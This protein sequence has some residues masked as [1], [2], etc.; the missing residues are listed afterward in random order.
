MNT[1][2]PAPCAPLSVWKI[3]TPHA[4]VICPATL[5]PGLLGCGEGL[6]KALPPL[7][8]QVYLRRPVLPGAAG[9]PRGRA[10]RRD[11]QPASVSAIYAADRNRCATGVASPAQSRSALAFP[12]PWV[13]RDGSEDAILP[14][15]SQSVASQAESIEKIPG[16]LGSS[17]LREFQ[18][19]I[20]VVLGQRRRAACPRSSQRKP[21]EVFYVPVQY[22]WIAAHRL[23]RISRPGW[24]GAGGAQRSASGKIEG[25]ISQ[26]G[27]KAGERGVAHL[28]PGS[29]AL[30]LHI[31][32]MTWRSSSGGTGYP[33]AAAGPH[34]APRCAP[35][36]YK[37]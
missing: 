25:D 6:R 27:K 15:N 32:A 34:G 29:A 28:T 9:R 18:H 14:G 16:H 7:G 30:P 11:L 5:G 2:R 31:G 37:G 35:R 36:L 33:H 26:V 23:L 13:S 1:G 3:E 10:Q 8:D 17:G 20:A 4:R 22:P 21:A 19:E 12:C 24:H